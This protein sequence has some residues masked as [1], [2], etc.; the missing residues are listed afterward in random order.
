MMR[1]L[2]EENNH[3]GLSVNINK[4]KYLCVGG[5]ITCLDLEDEQEYAYFGS[6]LVMKLEKMRKRSTN[7][8]FR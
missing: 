2:V 4:T 1:K 8:L 3:W 5:E 7:V 6:T